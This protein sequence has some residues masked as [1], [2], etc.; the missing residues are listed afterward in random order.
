MDAG[1]ACLQPDIETDDCTEGPCEDRRISEI[2]TK[3]GQG[4]YA[5]T[6][7]DVSVKVCH[8]SDPKDCCYTLL[9]DPKE[10]D[11]STTGKEDF[12]T[13]PNELGQCYNFVLGKDAITVTL[14]PEGDNA[15]EVEWA[16]IKLAGGTSFTC[17]FNKITSA[18]VSDGY[19]LFLTTVCPIDE[20]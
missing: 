14:T 2:S 4:D 10:E 9:D 3:T 16:K 7:E 13:R 19:D 6:D 18:E 20:E 5:M 8:G 17:T 11:R 1:F 12:Y 15:W